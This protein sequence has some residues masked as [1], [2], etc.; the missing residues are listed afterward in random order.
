MTATGSLKVTDFGTDQKL[1]CDLLLLNS[2]NLCPTSHHFE[3]LWPQKLKTKTLLWC[4][5]YFNIHLG[6]SH[7]CDRQRDGQD[8]DSNSMCV[9]MTHAKN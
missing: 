1:I 6:M 8:Y 3:L 9:S 2:T 5:T 7:Q 4:T